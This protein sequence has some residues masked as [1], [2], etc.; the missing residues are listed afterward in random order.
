M[1]S[2]PTTARSMPISPRAR[3]R[4]APL[5]DDRPWRVRMKK[6]DAMRYDAFSRL[7]VSCSLISSPALLG[8][9]LEHAQHAVGDQEATDHVDGGRG[10][11]HEA[12]GRGHLVVVGPGGYQR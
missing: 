5:G 8:L 2:V 10:H 9:G 11:R 6:S 4:R 7:S 3:P 12:Q 1:I